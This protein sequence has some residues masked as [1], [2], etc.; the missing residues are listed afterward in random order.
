MTTDALT[1][2]E[3]LSESAHEMH[4]NGQPDQAPVL[5]NQAGEVVTGDEDVP[6]PAPAERPLHLARCGEC[7]HAV[8]YRAFP[9]GSGFEL[10]SPGD[11]SYGIGPHG[12]PVCPQGHGEMAIADDQLPAA[13]AISQVAAQQQ[14]RARRLP[15]P[16]PP[17]DYESALHAIFKKRHQV[18]ALEER[19]EDLADRKKK[20]KE[21][22]DEA[23]LALG[24]MIEQY[25]QY[26]RERHDE[27]E[28]REA[29]A[30][31]AGAPPDADPLDQVGALV[32]R[33]AELGVRIPRN[34]VVALDDQART[35][36]VAWIESGEGA[37]APDANDRAQWLTER[38]L[39]L[40]TAHI[41]ANGHVS[42]SSADGGQTY[43]ACQVCGARL[44]SV[45]TGGEEPLDP[46]PAGTLVGVDCP[47]AE[48]APAEPHRY[49]P[50]RS[51]KAPGK[52]KPAGKGRGKK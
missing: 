10:E 31:A 29:M 26:E 30:A 7:S 47:G 36:L 40:G 2:D 13:D 11:E 24:K 32:A 45:T 35:E 37:L 3:P 14:Q 5:R 28:R 16:S 50:K 27:H 23:N 42:E 12:R 6:G 8:R 21:D 33:L 15:F 18:A 4:G 52:K 41:A 49:S 1:P 44:L 19:H 39:A 20:A 34:T 22:L 9:S 48:A 25:E 43:Q 38:P 51:A 46:Y 17:F